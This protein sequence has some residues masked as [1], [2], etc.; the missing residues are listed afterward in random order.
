[1]PI[2]F[3]PAWE[4]RE[5]DPE[6]EWAMG[7]GGD[8]GFAALNLD[9]RREKLSRGNLGFRFGQSEASLRRT[10]FPVARAKPGRPEA[11]KRACQK[12]GRRFTPRHKGTRYCSRACRPYIG[13]VRVLPDVGCGWCG[14]V[15]RPKYSANRF[16][17]RTCQGRWIVRVKTG[18]RAGKEEQIR[19]LVLAGL[20][21][22]AIAARL[23]MSKAGVRHTRVRLGLKS[24]AGVGN[25]K[26]KKGA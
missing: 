1:M 5:T 11:E 22:V 23:G 8:G 20:N 21:D 26:W 6:I 4:Y 3:D 25:P 14:K 15:F 17:S 16:C 24:P 10:D 12:C 7:G 2:E 18:R 13:S 19:G 9:W